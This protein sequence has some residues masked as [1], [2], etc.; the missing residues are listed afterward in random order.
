[1][2]SIGTDIGA[3]YIEDDL[4]ANAI[5][6]AGLAPDVE[7]GNLLRIIAGTGR[8]DVYRISG[9]T[10]IRITV[11]GGW[12]PTRVPDSTTRYIVER[13]E[14]LHTQ[15]SDRIDNSDPDAE[16]SFDVQVTNWARKT[17]LLQV[18]GI[19]GGKNE[20]IES[21]SPMR[22]IYVFGGLGRILDTEK[23]TI[24]AIGELVTFD[25]LDPDQGTAYSNITVPP[26]I[27]AEVYEVHFTLSDAPT[28]AAMILNMYRSEDEGATW[29]GSIFNTPPE[30]P[31]DSLG[32]TVTEFSETPL[33]LRRTNRVRLA[34]TQIGSTYAGANLRCVVR[35][36]LRE[37]PVA[38]AMEEAGSIGGRSAD[39]GTGRGS[40]Y[41]LLMM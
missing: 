22:E 34:C 24:N 35:Y 11:E 37:D 8:G 1:M 16:L 40:G 6:G 23:I 15:D 28:G 32:I 9:N 25:G 10:E 19:D 20:S 13:P 29:L 26:G 27:L 4:W 5:S 38:D 41:P 39:V 31:I 2:R 17:L 7:I 14:W 18:L 30:I 33:L 3:D 36:R 21:L 12:N